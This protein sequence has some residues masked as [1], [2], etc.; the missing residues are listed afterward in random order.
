[1]DFPYPRL[2]LYTT[3]THYVRALAGL[4][5]G[6]CA[7]GPAVSSLESRVV[8]DVGAKHAIAMPFARTGIYLIIK[9]LVRP[10]QSVILSPYTVS[11]VIN[12]V[13]CAGA[14][15]VFADVDPATCNIDPDAV[16]RL[17]DDNTGAVLVTHFFGLICDVDAIGALC[18][19]RNIPM[20]EDA[21]QAYGAHQGGRAAGA[22]GAA[23]VFSFNLYKTVTSFTGGMVVT[24]DDDL[25]DRLRHEIAAW[26]HRSPGAMVKSLASGLITDVATWRPIY[27]TAT[28]RVLRYGFINKVDAITNKMKNDV[29]PILRDV[30]PESW[31]HRMTALQAELALPGLDQVEKEMAARIERAGRY[32]EGLKDIK[33]LRL[34]PWRADGSHSYWYYPL[35]YKDRYALVSHVLKRGSDIAVSYHHNCAGLACFSGYGPACPAAEKTA[36]S[37]IYL[38]TYPSYPLSQ[39]D[40][41]V[42]D[43][44]SFFHGT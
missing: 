18:K 36:S 19:K 9:A 7:G 12:T 33:A 28:F 13:I 24:N 31:L 26:P 21:A 42:E 10:G 16:A 25:A 15:P 23:G 17:I 44:R 20:I 11:E 3:A 22:F 5:V 30:V 38:P 14:R 32:H 4:A 8:R 2:K 34:P 37:V 40:R 6:K 43:I 27:G 35:Q 1:M 41:L 39:V 29:R